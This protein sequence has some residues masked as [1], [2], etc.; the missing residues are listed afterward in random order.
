MG[1]LLQRAGFHLF[2]ALA[3]P[4]SALAA[5]PSLLRTAGG[6]SSGYR[7]SNDFAPFLMM[8]MIAV[9]DRRLTAWA[10]GALA[11]DG[12]LPA[13]SRSSAPGPLLRR[14]RHP[15]GACTSPDWR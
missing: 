6:S 7:F 1:L 11:G 14:R 15:E 8:L 9:G 3:S 13:R 4:P 2:R 10:L 12:Q 5:F